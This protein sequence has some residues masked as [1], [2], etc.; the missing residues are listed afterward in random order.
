MKTN[1]KKR[2]LSYILAFLMVF[3]YIPATAYATDNGETNENPGVTAASTT[4]TVLD[5]QIRIEDDF[6]SAVAENDVVTITAK[7]VTAG[8][9]TKDNIKIYNDS[10]K[11][12]I[13]SFDYTAENFSDFS[14]KKSG[15]IVN[16]VGSSN[17]TYT[18]VINSGEYKELYITGITK[19]QGDNSAKL[20]LNNFDYIL[21]SDES[22]V[23]VNYDGSLGTVVVD[24]NEVTPGGSATVTYNPGGTMEAIP[25]EG[26]RFA[27]WIDPATGKL[28]SR[29]LSYII[30][31]I[32]NITV[33]AVFMG[34]ETD[35]YYLVG[36]EYLVNGFNNAMNKVASTSDKT[37]VLLKDT[38]LDSGTY[39]VP[40]GVTFLVPFD[41]DNTLYT[42]E[43]VGTNEEYSTPTSYCT[44]TLA[45]NAE[46][47][48]NGAM[49]LSA[50]HY[51]ANGGGRGAG[52]PTGDVS[53]LDLGKG[54]K[55]TVNNGGALYAYGY[56]IG[57]GNVVAKNGSTIFENF[58]I[59]DFRGGEVTLNVAYHEMAKGLLPISQY[60]VQ[61][62]EVPLILEAGATEFVYTS[63]YT[64]NKV[65]GSSVQ[66][67]GGSKAMFNLKEGNAVKYY[68]STNDR[69]IF[70]IEG[71]IGL[72]PIKVEM[73]DFG[74]DS[75]MFDLP[76]NSNITVNLNSGD[77]EISQDISLLPGSQINIAEGANC[78]LAEGINVFIYDLEQW[79]GYVGSDN[80]K[81]IPVRYAPSRPN[82][83]TRTE[84]DLED[85]AIKVDGTFDASAGYLFTTAADG[86]TDGA[87]VYSTGSGIVKTKNGVAPELY[88][89]V[90]SGQTGEFVLI[91]LLPVNLKNKDGSMV[92][93]LE[94]G[95]GTYTYEDGQWICGHETYK[96]TVKEEAT[97]AK[98]GIKEVLC[99]M[100]EVQAGYGHKHTEVIPKLPHTSVTDNAVEPTCTTPGLTEG[101][102]CSVCKE[103]IVAQQVVDALGHAWEEEYTF[104]TEP[105]C[106][107]DGIR[108]IHCSRCDT[109]KEKSEETVK[110][111]GHAYDWKETPPTC[112]EAGEK[113][114]ECIRCEVKTET[115]VTE[116]LGHDY[117]H[118]VTDPTCTEEGYTSHI[119]SRCDDTYTDTETAAV[120]HTIVAVEKQVPT[121][122]EAGFEAHYSCAK[123]DGLFSDA[124]GKTAVKEADVEIKAL[125]HD[126]GDWV[127]DSNATCTE[128]GSKH[129]DCSRCDEVDTEALYPTGHTVVIDEAV[130]PTCTE[131]GLTEG[132]H[133]SECPA[134]MI[135][136][137]VVP[138]LGHTEV[139]DPAVSPTCT[140]PGLT[141][142]SHCSVCEETLVE[143]TVV[144]PT[145]HT[146]IIDEA[147]QPNCT[148]PGLTEGKHCTVCKL[149]TV[150]Q[151]TVD[152]LGHTEVVDPAVGATCINTGLTEGRHCDVCKEVLVAQEVVETGDHD[153]EHHGGKEATCTDKG[154]KP[155]D[156]CKLCDYTTYQEIPVAEH[157]IK[158]HVVGATC[159]EDGYT[160]EYC[161]CGYE[162][163]VTGDKATGHSFTNYSESV[164]ATCVKVGKEKATCDNGCGAVDV[165]D[166][167]LADHTP[168][169]DPAVEATCTE[170][171]LTEGSHCSVCEAVITEQKPVDV[172]PHDTDKHEA[173]AATC[174]EKGY[175]AYET[176]KDCDYTTYK[177]TDPLKHDLKL[178]DAKA[179][180][181]TE[182]G[183]EAYEECLREG[184]DYTTYEEKDPV[185]HKYGEEQYKVPT[186]E[187]VGG[188]YEVCSVCGDIKWN[189]KQTYIEYVKEAVESAAVTAKAEG[190]VKT[191]TITVSWTDDSA[192][193]LTYYNVYRSTSETGTFTYIGKSTSKSY[194]DKKA[195]VGKTYYYKVAG[196]RAEGEEIYKTK[197]SEAVS[198]K[199]KKV[200]Q[201]EVKATPM[202]GTTNYL[203]KGL[204][205]SWTSPNVKVDGYQVYRATSYN[206]TYKLLKETKPN[207]YTIK[208]TGL[209]VGKKYYYKVRGFKYV[210]GKKTYTKFSSKGYRIVL[211]G[212][213]ATIARSIVRSDA[214]TAKS[215]VKVSNGIKV[216]WSKKT[217]SKCNRY[218]VLR[219]TS[220]NGT[221]IKLART[222]NKYYVDKSA[223]SGKTYYYKIK[224]YRYF[225]NASAATNYSNVVSGKR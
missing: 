64:N 162:N 197:T 212:T 24:G 33:E 157:D 25:D 168:V 93:T 218:L 81:M 6:G 170:A 35:A 9:P 62:I 77:I 151:E 222:S 199:I 221:Y 166:T 182:I 79:G 103:V 213:S 144:D 217:T 91:D 124:E 47:I 11:S 136:Q 102:H 216:T 219:A 195:T 36:N 211:S 160:L 225:G 215:A 58:Q 60:Y 40:A 206:G 50:K 186:V 172:K 8:R 26:S 150:A 132:A 98:E 27:G 15:D 18:A 113:Y 59:E 94:T 174:T 135:E 39:T 194:V 159:L 45:E 143:Q 141:E 101:S 125:D 139:I 154:Y 13:L 177:E 187:E 85:A 105:T 209:K 142:G 175:E 156:T 148:E 116:A 48:I 72:S 137:E 164:H 181:C 95:V 140:A 57:E 73:A 100:E 208:N 63:L 38:T 119:C 202:Y 42:A 203:N 161:K 52:A 110:A 180:T 31:P 179:P 46:L 129:R 220:K 163:I 28:Y 71:D 205:V 90:Q 51:A 121:C 127:I 145:G 200:T 167:A 67:M 21:I 4:A 192:V 16:G 2:F 204:Q 54:S 155:Y 70:D 5:G 112:T 19:R 131:T 12:L 223:K 108:S 74:V 69:L 99:S 173:K 188:Y 169:T 191:E 17:G 66:F 7:G 149:V 128:R 117:K 107:T 106:T 178:Y 183:W 201:S 133:C 109:I 37:V 152:P 43:P 84:R 118:F 82:E 53:F 89:Y 55:V 96:E 49:S 185:G 189:K 153:L 29:E 123:C 146:E 41:D 126:F 122:T 1:A 86:S 196:R 75:S 120:G 30:N 65:Y 97:C 214:I 184:C 147:V 210:N 76:I 176:C 138:K 14:E 61:N 10:E 104:D 92:Q 134:V 22:T 115:E 78:I 34:T 224:G 44:L 83:E 190:S 130:D 32:E 88:Q 20:I 158:T 68:D 114:G 23:M 171:G 80:F 3:T 87:N 198:A 165:K 56:I 193:E 111:L 207:V